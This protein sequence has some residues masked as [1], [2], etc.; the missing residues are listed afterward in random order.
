MGPWSRTRALSRRA[1]REIRGA[2]DARAC[3]FCPGRQLPLLLTD[4]LFAMQPEATAPSTGQPS[5]GPSGGHGSGPAGCGGEASSQL[6]L[7]AVMFGVF[8]FLLIRP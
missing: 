8:Y 4:A 1:S 2:R 6:V 5:G 3:A 7:L